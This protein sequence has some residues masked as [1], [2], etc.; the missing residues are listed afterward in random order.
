LTLGFNKGGNVI[1]NLNSLIIEGVLQDDLLLSKTDKTG[2]LRIKVV[3]QERTKG[4]TSEESVFTVVVPLPLVEDC[5]RLM[6]KG[7]GVRIVG[8]LKEERWVA[9]DG[10]KS[11]VVVVAEHIEFNGEKP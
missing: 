9:I 1:S 7:R 11:R 2:L 3:R 5:Q 4:S 8:R 6:H 10:N